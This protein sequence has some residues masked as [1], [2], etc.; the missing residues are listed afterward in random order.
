MEINYGHDKEKICVQYA[1]KKLIINLNVTCRNFHN[2]QLF[3]P[4]SLITCPKNV[5]QQEKVTRM[6]QHFTYVST[7]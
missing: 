7:H 5:A 4:L 6:E 1:K 2:L 3:T